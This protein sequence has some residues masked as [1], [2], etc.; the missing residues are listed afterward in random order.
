[1]EKVEFTL[2]G[3]KDPKTKLKSPELQP[4]HQLRFSPPSPSPP[5]GSV[6]LI[7]SEDASFRDR[8]M[9][10]KP[11]EGDLLDPATTI[12]NGDMQTKVPLLRFDISG[13]G[14]SI[15]SDWKRVIPPPQPPPAQ[16]S[17]SAITHV[18]MNAL[19]GRTSS[20][21]VEM[22]AVM[23]PFAVPC[24]KAIKISRMN[25]GV[26]LCHEGKWQAVSD[27]RYFYPN[28]DIITHP[29]VIRGVKNVSN[30]DDVGVTFQVDGVP[31]KLRKVRF[32]CDVEIEDSGQVRSIRGLQLD[33]CV[34]LTNAGNSLST[35]PDGALW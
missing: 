22:Q 20:E 13:Y 30:I 31:L 8:A 27:G 17:P 29:G 32:D 23:A 28:T 1:M 16:P 24:V 6:G 21:I 35:K 3:D 9:V 26:V 33:G 14:A 2:G 18:Q 11:L 19:T 10:L 5:G 7:G 15:F 25:S 34:F 12:F 4:A